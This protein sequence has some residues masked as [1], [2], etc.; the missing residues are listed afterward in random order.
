[1]ITKPS[2]EK[3]LSN[4]PKKVV[5]FFDGWKFDNKY[6]STDYRTVV[7]S[8]SKEFGL[9]NAPELYSFKIKV[10]STEF[11][12]DN[13]GRDAI[14]VHES[15][16]RISQINLKMIPVGFHLYFDVKDNSIRSTFYFLNYNRMSNEK[17]VTKGITQDTYNI[18]RTKIKERLGSHFSF[19]LNK[20]QGILA[21]T[22]QPQSR[23]FIDKSNNTALISTEAAIFDFVKLFGDNEYRVAISRA[24][25]G[26][27]LSKAQK[28]TTA[29]NQII[30]ISGDS[31]IDNIKI[32]S[33]QK[34]AK[35][36]SV[37]NINKRSSEN[38]LELM[39]LTDLLE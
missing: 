4:F 12:K 37:G 38:L 35:Q 24:L 13:F 32:P 30:A 10:F 21:S 11:T 29:I 2:I 5:S 14:R 25:K 27:P 33:K 28:L 22:G 39:G 1:M 19:S 20:P 7:G 9:A 3:K 8:L 23:G 6:F 31:S 36:V 17:A 15:I 34:Q 26:L 16:L 18:L